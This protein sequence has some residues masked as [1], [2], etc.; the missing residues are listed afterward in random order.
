[1]ARDILYFGNDWAEEHKTS[2]HHI[3]EELA[4]DHR[5]FYIESSG[6]RT[7][8][9]VKRDITKI[10]RKAKKLFAGVHER[11]KNLYVYCLPQLPFHGNPIIRRI[12]RGLAVFSLKRLIRKFGIKEHLLWFIVPQLSFLKGRLKERAVVYYCVE[13]YSAFPGIDKALVSLLDQEMSDRAD[14]IFVTSAGLLE[15]KKRTDKPVIYSP[16]AVDFAHFNKASLEGPIPEDIKEIKKPVI[17]MFGLIEE[18]LDLELLKSV[19]AIRPDWNFLL[20]GK[21]MVDVSGLGGLK[22]V[23]FIGHRAYEA[24]PDY[25]RV[26]DV[27]LIMFRQNERVK[28]INPLKLK[29]YLAT[30]K[31]IVSAPMR[32]MA[33]YSDLISIAD[34]PKEFCAKIESAMKNDFA[35]ARKTRIELVRQDSW[36]ALT[37]RTLGEI[38][39]VLKNKPMDPFV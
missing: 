2:S 1:M 4:R 24:L 3:A 26:F 23:H 31:P 34:N 32:E 35:Q 21:V 20:I 30:G 29:E 8:H 9:L 14:I 6:L 18:R 5:V 16:H 38:E 22:N 10:L 17:G 39:K 12:N 7:P 28:F 11:S 33:G 13:D 36:Q 25:A 37:N 27:C 19:A 15:K